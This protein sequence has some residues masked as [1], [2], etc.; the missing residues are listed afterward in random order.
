MI[1][2]ERFFR[3]MFAFAGT[4]LITALIYYEVPELWQPLAGIA[5]AVILLEVGQRISYPVLAWHSHLLATLAALA[6]VTADSSGVQQW[7]NIPLHAFAALPV[8]AGV[9]W[10]ACRIRVPNPVT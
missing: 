4:A 1:P 5:F 8:V 3:G 9:Y 2:T 6:A 7:H 10:I